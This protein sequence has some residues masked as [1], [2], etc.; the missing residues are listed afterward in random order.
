MIT[1]DELPVSGDVNSVLVLPLVRL[2][3]QRLGQRRIA[4]ELNGMRIYQ[5]NGKPWNQ[6]AMARY[7]QNHEIQ[8]A[9]ALTIFP[10]ESYEKARTDK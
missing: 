5:A 2:F 1:E 7:M 6:T 9:W 4:E 8:P 3:A 10:P